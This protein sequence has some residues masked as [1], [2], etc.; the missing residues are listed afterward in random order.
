MDPK[1]GF[2]HICS[3]ANWHKVID[4]D[5][6]GVFYVV[7][8]VLVV[9][10]QKN[11]LNLGPLHAKVKAHCQTVIS[12]PDLLL[13]SDASYKTGAM[14]GR[15]WQHP[16][17][18]YAVQKWIPALPHIQGALVVFFRG[19]LET[20]G[21][22]TSEYTPG[23]PITLL[24]PKE[25][26][27]AFM[28]TT[29][30]NN[31]GAL[32][33]FHVGAQCAPNMSLVQWNAHQMYQK[34]KTE[35]FCHHF[36]SMQDWKYCHWVT[37]EQDSSGAKKIFLQAQ[38]EVDHKATQEKQVKEIAK[39]AK[40]NTAAARIDNVEFI[41]DLSKLHAVPCMLTVIQ[42]NLLLDWHH[43]NGNAEVIPMKKM[44]KHKADKLKVLIEVVEG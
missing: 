44:L 23:A 38:A 25:C 33:A 31:E 22:F 3:S 36:F 40:Y 20:W 13:G 7:K 16:E 11:V 6:H 29:N 27:R 42:I 15:Q 12:N 5:L 9:Q 14:D 10:E 30:D 37:R 18:F 28:K 32:R 43:R 34:N 19:A 26:Y 1:S 4:V 35:H 2:L 41:L 24:T 21:R 39:K 8:A 17:V